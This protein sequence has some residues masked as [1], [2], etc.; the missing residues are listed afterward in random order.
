MKKIALL[1]TT[2][3]L[4]Q[5]AHGQ[6]I[7]SAVPG[8]ISYQGRALDTTGAVIGS[9]TPVN[10]TVTFRVWDHPSNVLLA[11]LLYSEQ[12]TVTISGGEFSVLIGQGVA[13]AGTVFGYS[14][15]TKGVPTVKISDLAVFGGSTRYLGVT[16]DDGTVAVDNEITPRQ[17][18]VSSAYAFRA[19]Y[20]EQL[21]SNGGAALTALDSGNVG[22]GNTS[23]PALFTVSGANTST[24][25]S[26]PQLLVTADDISERLRIGVDSTGNGT[27]FIQ[28]YKESIGAQNLLLNPSGGNV[29]IGTTSPS[30]ALSVTGAITATG[31]ITG[32]SFS[33]AGAITATGAITGGS[34][35]TQGAITG[36]GIGIT[37]AITAS[38]NIT[39]SGG[40]IGIGTTSPGARLEID[41]G[42]ADSTKYG[43]VQITRPATGHTAAHLSFVRAGTTT[44]G[45]GYGQSSSIFGFGP[46]TTG[47]F[48]PSWLGIDTAGNVGIGTASPGYKLDV[49]G[50]AHVGGQMNVDGSIVMGDGPAIYGKNTTGGA[51]PAFWPRSANG[52]Y[53]NHGTGGLFIRDNASTLGVYVAAGKMAVGGITDTG[54]G[55]ITAN[56][57]FVATGTAVN[58]YTSYAKMSYRSDRGG[59]A[60]DVYNSGQYANAWR[61][62]SYDGDSN[63]DWYSDRTM[64]KDIV[65]A[66]PMLDRLMQVPFRRFH[67]KDVSD[68][69]VKLEFGVIAQEVELFFPDIVATGADGMKT[70]G[71]TTFATIACK[72]LQEYKTRTDADLSKLNEQIHERDTKIEALEAKLAA[73]EKRAATQV[74]GNADKEQRMEARLIALEQRLSKGSAPETVSIKTANAAK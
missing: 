15:T 25:T 36:T 50:T 64:K 55:S 31:A 58:G 38:T 46:G 40:N 24:T 54:Q 22:I 14:E 13:T 34:L 41:D 28:A 51:E 67:W 42:A 52:T 56:N 65:D 47:A 68:P 37:G 11:N 3:C 39:T 74:D 63:I 61:G 6:T 60:F 57:G 71:Y 5:S 45:L 66:E 23:P 9:T 73:Q 2:L 4:L 17:Q 29:G 10:R 7:T 8:F 48:S 16:I 32:G 21:G 49:S 18:I 62:F 44:I 20:A 12:Q 19:K 72:A 35:A 59:I 70:V 43:S 27:G 26:T 30:V 53:L 33:T 69:A 1:F